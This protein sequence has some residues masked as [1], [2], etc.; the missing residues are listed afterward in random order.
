[1]KRRQFFQVV[2]GVS[3]AAF[4]GVRQGFATPKK[5]GIVGGGI[6]GGSLAYHL[7]RRGAE[8]FLF[9]K[10]KPASGA[11]ANSFAWINASFS[12]RPLHYHH[13]NS[14]GAL[15]YRHL[16]R[17][18]GGDLKVQWGGTLEWYDEADRARWLRQQVRSK[19]VWGYPTRLVDVDTFKALE[20]NVEPGD[21]LTA[22]HTE[23]EGS[24]DP[25]EAT[26]VLMKHAKK[27][28]ARIE[29]PCEVT[30]IDLEWGRLKGVTTNQGVFPLDVIVIAAGTD[31]P[32]LAKLVGL[33]VPLVESPGVLAHTKPGQR[34]IER[35]VLSP[36]ANMKQKLDGRIVAGLGFG[37]APVAKASDEEGQKVLQSGRQYLKG[38]EKFEL[39]RVTLGYRPV[40]RD[41]F[42]IV[43][44]AEG[45][46]DIYVSVMHSGVT[47]S[48]V[49][50]RLAALEILE[51]L[52][53][54]LLS[55]YR[56]ARFEKRRT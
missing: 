45:A 49:I 53:V 42:P 2:A 14:L 18:L 5:V 28:G 32:K 52:E 40:P 44:F 6:L 24:I 12:K 7:A 17:E 21:V 31:T 51:G 27:Q 30:S 41:G 4:P 13:I 10:N 56:Y 26:Q 33:D 54:Q 22:A 38:L 43:G 55:P 35:I 25:V 9:E 23:Q 1:M 20:P 47:L 11:T 39:E 36:G 46:P 50:G 37:S 19:Q 48:P 3:V 8:V 29:Y 34:L 16:E 15:G